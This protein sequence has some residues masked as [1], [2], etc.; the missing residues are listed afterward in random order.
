LKPSIIFN[1]LQKAIF[2]ITLEEYKSFFPGNPI[3]LILGS[4]LF[5]SNGSVTEVSVQTLL[6]FLHEV[7]RICPIKVLGFEYISLVS[8]HQQ[9]ILSLG[10]VICAQPIDLYEHVVNRLPKLQRLSFGTPFWIMKP[11]SVRPDTDIQLENVTQLS[12]YDMCLGDQKSIS[13]RDFFAMFH[14]PPSSM[15]KLYLEINSGFSPQDAADM[16][17]NNT[18]IVELHMQFNTYEETSIA[19]SLKPV[20]EAL[21]HNSTLK[22][23]SFPNAYRERTDLARGDLEAFHELIEGDSCRHRGPCNC[24]GGNCT[25]EILDLGLV[26]DRR[27]YDD[28]FCLGSTV[29]PQDE[30]TVRLY[31]GIYFVLSLNKHCNRKHVV[32][33]SAAPNDEWFNAVIQFKD[34]L[35]VFF[36]YLSHSP[37]IFEKASPPSDQEELLATR[38]ELRAARAE[39]MSVR[40]ENLALWQRFNYWY[41]E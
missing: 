37:A 36:Y 6:A 17:R 3:E 30:E 31:H 16:L 19:Y 32:A 11:P 5:E 9:D 4:A 28:F 25:L 23:F 24:L 15:K 20:V 34:N 35:S 41:H 21:R 40:A 7:D 13:S 26:L 12:I 39:L 33:T 22:V 8:D 10:S 29:L 18:T 1:D 2:F 38:A 14:D 27:T